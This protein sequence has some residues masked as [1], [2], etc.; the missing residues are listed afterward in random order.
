LAEKSV[1]ELLR[2]RRE[3]HSLVSFAGMRQ[4]WDTSLTFTLQLER[5]SGRKAYGLRSTLLA[6][7]KSFVERKHEA[8]MSAL[9]AALDS[10]RWIQCNVSLYS[11]KV[12]MVS[13]FWPS[14]CFTLMFCDQRF[15]PKDKQHLTACVQVEQHLHL[16]T[17]HFAIQIA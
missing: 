1:A 5:F 4:L 7:A 14:F 15:R 9:V 8:N 6:Q 12:V 17:Q 11:F 16:E 2:L 10:E 3:A 13:I